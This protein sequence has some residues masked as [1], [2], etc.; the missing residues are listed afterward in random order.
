MPGFV[1]MFVV[2]GG[3]AVLI[4]WLVEQRRRTRAAAVAAVLGLQYLP[5]P[6]SPPDV[7][8]RQFSIGRSRKVRHTF[9]R[10]GD[11]LEATVFQ[12]QYTT[13]SGKDSQTHHCTCAMFRTG[14][15]APHLVLDRQGFFRDLLGKLGL[16]DIQL[17]SPQF[18]ETWHV[19]CDDER[20]AVTVLD[21]PM[22]GWLMTTG[23]GGEIEIELYGDRGLA[24]TRRRDVEQIPELLDYA[25]QFVAQ[26]PKVVHEL[27]SGHR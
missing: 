8:F 27:Y 2:V 15:R 26:I 25:H 6:T 19:S 21:P 1:V 13:G 20:F 3:A 4:S 9:W 10:A 12:Y 7:P 22:M 23:G 17:E 24:T 18:N 16:R 11:S 14:L 5:G